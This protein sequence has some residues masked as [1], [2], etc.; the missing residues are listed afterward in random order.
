MAIALK[1]LDSDLYELA[2][3]FPQL[4]PTATSPKRFTSFCSIHGKDKTSDVVWTFDSNDLVVISCKVCGNLAIDD[5]RNPQPKIEVKPQSPIIDLLIDAITVDTRAQSRSEIDMA[6]V[7]EY[8]D[9]MR[10]GAIFPPM[11]VLHDET[12][13]WLAEGFHRIAAYRQAGIANCPCI[14]R[15]GGL[16][17]AILLSLGSNSDHGKRRT[18]ADK[19]HAIELVLKDSEWSAWSD[20]EIA[21]QCRVDHKTVGSVRESY[22]GISPDAS[23]NEPVRK[24]TRSGKTYTVKTGNIGK[25]KAELVKDETDKLADSTTQ[26]SVKESIGNLLVD[27]TQEPDK[28]ESSVFK[29]PCEPVGSPFSPPGTCGFIMLRSASLQNNINMMK[30]YGVNG[31]VQNLRE[32]LFR[33]GKRVDDDSQLPWNLFPDMKNPVGDPVKYFEMITDIPWNIIINLIELTDNELANELLRIIPT[34]NTDDNEIDKLRCE[35][36][37]IKSMVREVYYGKAVVRLY[38]EDEIAFD[39]SE[40]E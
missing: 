22:L 29:F 31:I 5:I 11:T 33:D 25:A 19:R 21:K 37:Y 18:I 32:L 3:E 17:D 36:A 34:N 27:T 2:I 30:R 28:S 1:N 12:I 8:A 9:A 20:R 40:R 16:R 7:T 14:V 23:S 6:L 35:L 24:A 39:V 10:D 4:K 38:D 13:Y 15:S 26:E